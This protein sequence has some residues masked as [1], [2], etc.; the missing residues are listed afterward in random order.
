[1]CMRKITLISLFL[2]PIVAFAQIDKLKEGM[3][4]DEVRGIFP[5]IKVETR[6]Q[7]E[8]WIEKDTLIKPTPEWVFDFKKGHLD[9][10]GFFIWDGWEYS[11]ESD[12]IYSLFKK[13]ALILMA[14]AE[15]A[16]G[17]PIADT[18]KMP[19]KYPGDYP[20]GYNLHKYL[21]AEWVVM[22]KKLI[23]E[24]GR[25]PLSYYSGGAMFL[26]IYLKD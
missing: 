23:M 17:K 7:Y 20:E 5:K 18:E 14:E 12:D 19:E 4:V 10:F 15:K 8:V 3:T 24:F 26:Q 1:M 25:N 13:R 9:S 16:Y 21:S 11:H 2:L 6:G 22:G